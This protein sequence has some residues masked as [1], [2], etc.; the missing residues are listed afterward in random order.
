MGYISYRQLG[1]GGKEAPRHTASYLSWTISGSLQQ[2]F[3]LQTLFSAHPLAADLHFTKCILV[4]DEDGNRPS[5][6]V[7]QKIR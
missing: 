7:G 5:G 1:P 4:E 2:T 6:H 3:N